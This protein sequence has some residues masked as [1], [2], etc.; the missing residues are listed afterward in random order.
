LIALLVLYS[1]WHL[2]EEAVSVLM[3]NA[4][5]GVD[6]HEIRTALLQRPGVVDVHDLHVWTITSGLPALSVHVVTDQAGYDAV[7]HDAR[8]TLH[9]EFGIDHVTVQ[10]EPQGF[11]E[12]ACTI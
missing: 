1:A 2:V 6:V 9:R 3:E 10:V 7:L 12:R 5:S 11:E 8:A 4:P